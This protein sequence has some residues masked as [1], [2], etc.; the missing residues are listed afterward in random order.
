MKLLERKGGQR[1][2]PSEGMGFL[3]LGGFMSSFAGLF[4]NQGVLN[5]ASQGFGHVSYL[6]KMLLSL[7]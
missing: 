5:R 2:L 3:S 7:C 1:G 6:L 4:S